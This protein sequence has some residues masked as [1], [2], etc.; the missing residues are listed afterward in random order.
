MSISENS[1]HELYPEF[2]H[3]LNQVDA[4][5]EPAGIGELFLDSLVKSY[6]QGTSRR[7]AIICFTKWM[8]GFNVTDI[9]KDMIYLAGEVDE[10]RAAVDEGDPDHFVEEL[11][12]V[13]IYCYGIAQM[14]NRDLDAAIMKK[15]KYNL[16]RRYKQDEEVVT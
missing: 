4:G 6:Q 11:A 12:D 3:A 8:H 15:M 14:V 10:A 2:L 1:R 9:P 16:E 7:Q 5:K 13:A